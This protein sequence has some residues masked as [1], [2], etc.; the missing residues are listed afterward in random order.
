MYKKSIIR[1]AII[2]SGTTALGCLSGIEKYLKE[3]PANKNLELQITHYSDSRDEIRYYTNTNQICRRLGFYGTSKNWHAVSPYSPSLTENF[4]RLFGD[5]YNERSFPDIG[6]SYYV[7]YFRPN[8]KNLYKK[9]KHRLKKLP[10]YH[11]FKDCA[12]Y[13]TKISKSLMDNSY[14]IHTEDE[15]TEIHDV[16][17]VCASVLDLKDIDYDNFS[18]PEY[19]LVDHDQIH[20]GVFRNKNFDSLAGKVVRRTLHGFFVGAIL[21]DDLLMIRPWHSKISRISLANFQNFGKSTFSIIRETIKSRS[22]G[23][24]KEIFF[25]RFGFFQIAEYYSVWVQTRVVRS[26][27]KELL[28][29]KFEKVKVEQLLEKHQ[30]F[31][32]ELP[33]FQVTG[34]AIPGNHIVGESELDISN[35]SIQFMTITKKH[36]LDGKHHSLLLSQQASDRAFH[37]LKGFLE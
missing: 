19:T 26:G 23:K 13:V 10:Q 32:Q 16:V 25:T 14:T 1:V 9:L 29:K 2:G 17:F 35:S 5:L 34:F 12:H 3:L 30:A 28:N 6:D 11:S 33:D 24:F 37:L 15:S 27:S 20:L 22:I 36:W 31:L 21:N 8:L 18:L 7:P 4:L